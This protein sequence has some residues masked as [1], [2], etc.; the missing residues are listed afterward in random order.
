MTTKSSPVI[1]LGEVLFDIFPQEKCLG[2]APFNFAFHLHCL[3]VPVIFISRVGEDALG[4]AILDFAGK[5]DFPAEG[6]QIDPGHSTGEVQVTF[7]AS[8]S[9]TFEILQDRAW[10]YIERNSYLNELLQ[11]RPP[12]VY[13]GSLAQRNAV[14]FETIRDVLKAFSHRSTLF[15]D[16]NLR[17]PFYNRDII[18][19]SLRFCDILKVSGEELDELKGIL[20]LEKLSAPV[21]FISHLHEEYKIKWLCVTKGE[22]GSELYE[23]GTA[24]PILQPVHPPECVADTVGAG[25]AFSAMLACGFLKNRP[26]PSILESASLFASKICGIKGALPVDRNFYLPFGGNNA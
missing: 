13:F 3:G 24:G 6:I 23:A 20:D 5:H 12:L 14:S 21:Q 22:G 11:G 17:P 9:H 19:H 16:L 8:G 15:M 10:D 18:E 4:R 1:V 2:G 7:D 26:T 25:D